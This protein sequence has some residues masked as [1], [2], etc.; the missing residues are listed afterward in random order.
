MDS[1]PLKRV[2]KEITS[3]N[4]FLITSHVNPEG[5]AIGSLI[6]MFSLLVKMGKKA[7]MVNSDGVPDYLMFMPMSDRI[8]QDLPSEFHP[9]T[10]IVLDCPVKERVGRIADYMNGSK[11]VI[12]IDHHVSNSYFGD[13]NWVEEEASSVGEMIYDLIKEAGLDINKETAVALYT[14]MITD[15]GGF[16][17][18]N[19]SRKTHEMI[20]ELVERGISPR[21]MQS[22]IF[23][24]KSIAQIRLL[25][26]TLSTVKVEEDGKLAYMCL[27]KNMYKEEGVNDVST[28][29]F[30]N[31]PRSIKGVVVTIFFKEHPEK[32][33]NI[34]VS[35]RSSGEVDVNEVAIRLGGGGHKMASGCTLK[36]NLKDA[37]AEVLDEVR[38]AIKEIEE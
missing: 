38:S 31:Y 10:V 18:D 3:R 17:Y 32:D 19:T 30:I 23:E 28:E 20:G 6:A 29:E 11:Y 34:S 14:A 26:K 13:V 35:F 27:T 22:E 7:V 36:E 5:D 12:N 8:H 9:E 21:K 16:N 4:H 2:M 1:N 33:G 25:G 24:K 15:T 37:M